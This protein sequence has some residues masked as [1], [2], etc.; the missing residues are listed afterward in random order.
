MRLT[1]IALLASALLCQVTAAS[2]TSVLIEKSGGTA[3]ARVLPSD[4]CPIHIQ[5]INAQAATNRVQNLY[6]KPASDLTISATRDAYAATPWKF[7]LNKVVQNLGGDVYFRSNYPGDGPAAPD[8]PQSCSGYVKGSKF[9]DVPL[10][11][12]DRL[13]FFDDDAQA[14][15]RLL[16][17]EKN[18]V[19]WRKTVQLGTESHCGMVI[20]VK[21]PL[22]KV[23]TIAGEKWFKT[24]QLYPSGHRSCN[25]LNGV[26]QE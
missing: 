18:N 21:P 23:Q 25:F 16:D 20:E 24:S 10:G 15:A 8:Q 11:D 7:A 13:S 4:A 14:N 19:A 5:V 17:M 2:A 12:I 9:L 1:T 26:Y 6:F 22:V 3:I